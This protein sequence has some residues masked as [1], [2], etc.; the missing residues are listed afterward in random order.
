MVRPVIA[1]AL[2]SGIWG[3]VVQELPQRQSE[4]ARPAFLCVHPGHGAVTGRWAA[5]Q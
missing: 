4:V 3:G 1:G 2:A 5:C